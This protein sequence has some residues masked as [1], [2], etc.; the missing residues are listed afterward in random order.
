MYFD[1]DE[2]TSRIFVELIHSSVE[3]VAGDGSAASSL[4]WL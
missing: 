2:H 4:A 1:D 3:V